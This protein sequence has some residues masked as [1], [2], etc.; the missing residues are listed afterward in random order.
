MA[1]KRTKTLAN[2][3]GGGALTYNQSLLNGISDTFVFSEEILRKYGVNDPREI[4]AVNESIS[5]AHKYGNKEIKRGIS[6]MVKGMEQ[7]VAIYTE[8][9]SEI[10]KLHQGILSMRKELTETREQLLLAETTASH[11]MEVCCI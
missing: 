3:S 11:K 4:E 9:K 8:M 2:I 1:A 7:A 5:N 6:N 10:Q